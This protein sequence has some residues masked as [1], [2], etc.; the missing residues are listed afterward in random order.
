MTSNTNEFV[1]VKRNRTSLNIETNN[2]RRGWNFIIAPATQ[3]NFVGI[4]LL[5]LILSGLMAFTSLSNIHSSRAESNTFYS[6]KNSV[7]KTVTSENWVKE[8]SSLSDSPAEKSEELR[9][10]FGFKTAQ[11]AVILNVGRKTLYNWSNNP[12]GKIKS[13]AEDR[14]NIL[15]EFSK[16]FRSEHSRYFSKLLFGRFSNKNLRETFTAKNLDLNSMLKAYDEVYGELDGF[17]VR[18][19]LFS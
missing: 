2:S 18:A 8:V 12:E 19:D 17:A 6:D 9:Q 14:L 7:D 13:E 1:Y 16:E 4:S 11:W 3:S 5:A 10:L 15:A